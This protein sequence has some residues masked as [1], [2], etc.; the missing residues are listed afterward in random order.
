MTSREPNTRRE[1]RCITA[2][3]R[4][5]RVDATLRAPCRRE[6]WRGRRSRLFSSVAPPWSSGTA[7]CPKICF[8]GQERA[9]FRVARDTGGATRKKITWRNLAH[10]PEYGNA[11]TAAERSGDLATRE[12]GCATIG[13]CDSA[14]RRYR[15]SLQRRRGPSQLA[16]HAGS[17]H[18]SAGRSP[19]RRSQFSG[20][21]TLRRSVL[22]RGSPRR[23]ANSGME[24]RRPMRTGPCTAIR[25]RASKVRSLSPRPAKTSA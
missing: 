20:R 6:R 3:A 19:F 18:R 9:R 11:R 2:R 4:S 12:C 13:A 8:S 25:S 7:R 10:L 17:A 14:R 15:V 22:T 23:K 21:P 5:A 16:A 1:R 24:S